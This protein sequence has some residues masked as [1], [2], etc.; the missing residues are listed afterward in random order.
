[1]PLDNETGQ[2]APVVDNAA[3]TPVTATATTA[4][5]SSDTQTEDQDEKTPAVEKTFTQT[6]LNE[7]L[8]KRIARAESK[9]ERRVIQALERIAPQQP[10]QYQPHQAS[11]RPQRDSY[12]SQES[13]EDGLVDW[14]IDQRESVGK[15]QKAQEQSRAIE[16]KTENMYAEAAKIPGFD[17]DDFNEL[18]LTPA[19]VQ[20]IVDSDVAPKLMAYM[21]ANPADVAR[22]AT[23]SP[24]R[25][26]AE[27][28][29]LETKVAGQKAPRVSNAPDPITTIGSQGGAV[30]SL[31]T[32]TMDEYIAMRKKQGARWAR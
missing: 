5:T 25:Q 1:M 13:Y 32:A 28:G 3:T 9:A 8:E 17:R 18:P 30:K 31:A 22:I 26:A 2:D 23:L 29:K 7:I 21:A 19:I 10:Q 15:Q 27:L 20:T 12:A 11:D 6:E 16:S 4:T 24:A 14:K